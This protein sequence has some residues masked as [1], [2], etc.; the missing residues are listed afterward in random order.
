MYMLKIGAYIGFA[1]GVALVVLAFVVPEAR[2]GLM[3]GAT[4][5]FLAAA[6]DLWFYRFFAPTI[7]DLPKPPGM[8]K[9]DMT[10]LRGSM[11]VGRAMRQQGLRKMESATAT[12]KEMNRSNRLQQQGKKVKAEVLAIRDTGQ[13]VNFDPILE[14]DLRIHPDGDGELYHVGGY[15]QI[16]S[17]IVY[18]RIDIGGRYTAFVDPEDPNSLFINWS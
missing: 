12:L 8:E 10:T 1:V 17:K 4:S 9:E 15:R 2:L 3:I 16:V 5:C 14:F 13:L 11:H 18:P 6:I 7:R